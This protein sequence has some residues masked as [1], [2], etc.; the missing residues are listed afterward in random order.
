MTAAQSRAS[1]LLETADVLLTRHRKLLI[2]GVS[3]SI[4]APLIEQA[5]QYQRMAKAELAVLA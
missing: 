4:T 3:A 5:E 2:A 1:A